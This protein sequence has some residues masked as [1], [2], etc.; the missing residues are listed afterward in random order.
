M[1]IEYLVKINFKTRRDEVQTSCEYRKKN[2]KPHPVRDGVI[3]EGN[4]YGA[5]AF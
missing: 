1:H 4:L 2:T 3:W 5:G